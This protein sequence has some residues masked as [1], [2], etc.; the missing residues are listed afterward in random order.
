MRNYPIAEG[1][2]SHPELIA[3]LL[4]RSWSPRKQVRV[5]IFPSS[6]ARSTEWFILY[7]LTR[8][9]IA[10]IEG[11]QQEPLTRDMAHETAMTGDI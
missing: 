3:E 1:S 10:T 9:G 7:G 5:A 8:E 6:K 4:V 2:A 11:V